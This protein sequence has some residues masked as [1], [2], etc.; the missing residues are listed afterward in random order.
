MAQTLARWGKKW[1][2]VVVAPVLPGKERAADVNGIFS[3]QS[4]KFNEKALIEAGGVLL[5]VFKVVAC[6]PQFGKEHH[7]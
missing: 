3:G 6:G 4:S 1:S 7:V 2:G 5:R